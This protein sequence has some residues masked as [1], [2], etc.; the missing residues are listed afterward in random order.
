M[1]R[2]YGLLLALTIVLGL[3]FA[4]A[5][6]AADHE[7]AAAGESSGEGGGEEGKKITPEFEYLQLDPLNLPIVTDG[8]VLQQISLVVSLEM[9]FG[10]LEK[11][12]QYQPK[13]ADAYI[14]DLYGLLGMGHGLMNG[15]V[16]DVKM[17]KDRLALITTKVLG[18]DMVKD[19]LLQVVQQRRI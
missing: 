12:K 6:F 7:N 10:N 15:N 13:L 5:V 2:F 11:V 1:K 19:V 4:P 9:K 16:L 14:Q 18:P 17:I 3:G 8:G